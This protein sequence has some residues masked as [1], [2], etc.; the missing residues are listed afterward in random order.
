MRTGNPARRCRLSFRSKIDQNFSNIKNGVLRAVKLERNHRNEAI[1]TQSSTLCSGFVDQTLSW[2][3]WKLFPTG[4]YAIIKKKKKKKTIY[5]Y[6]N[7]L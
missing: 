4:T 3:F 7:E 1:S 5:P 2:G 6:K